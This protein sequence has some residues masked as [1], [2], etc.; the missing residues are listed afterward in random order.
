ATAEIAASQDHRG[1]Q[2]WVKVYR[3]NNA[4]TILGEWKAYGEVE[5]GAKVA[6]G[7]IDGDAVAEVVTGAGQG[8]GPQVLAFEKDGYRINSNFFAYDKNF[9]GG[10]NVAVGQ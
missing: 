5:V 1:D 9:R 8:G 6:M 7:D 2:S 10:V 3:Y 4:K